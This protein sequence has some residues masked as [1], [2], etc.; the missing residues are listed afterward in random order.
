MSLKKGENT[1]GNNETMLPMKGIRTPRFFIWFRGFW[2]GKIIHTGGIDP[3]T[4]IIVSGYVTGQIKRFRNACITRRE[5]AEEK[6]SKVWSTADEL[7]IDYA[8]V[9]VALTEFGKG[10]NSHSESNAQARSNEREAEKR[11]SCENERQSILKNL[12]QLANDIRAEYGAAHDQMESTAE[13][14]SSTFACYGHGLLM[15]PIYDYN[16]PSITYEDCPQ[17]I[18]N[19]HEDTWKAIISI[20]KEVKE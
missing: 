2:H 11:A 17:Q 15:K 10:Q 1:M 8:S 7:L 4:N 19:N 3:E 18:L 16:L 12:A 6:L 20:L 5:K 13:I 14:L 9:T